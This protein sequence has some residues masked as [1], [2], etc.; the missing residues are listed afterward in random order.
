MKLWKNATFYQMTAEGD[1]V[2]AVLTENGQICAVGEAMGLEKQYVANITE[3]IDLEGKVVFPGFVDAHIHLLWYGQALERL[4]LNQT[5]T[6]KEALALIAERTKQIASDEWLFV[7]G[8]DENKW[9][10]E[11]T[12]ISLADLD[13][14]SQ[15]NPILVRRIDYHSVSINSALQEKIADFSETGFDGGGEIVRDKTGEFIGVLRDNATTMAIDSFPAATPSELSAW[16]EIAITDLWSKGITGAHSEDL[17]YFTGF[18][19]TLAAFRNTIGSNKM[20]FRAH[21]LVH[22]AELAAFSASNESFVSG[23]AF[24]ELGAMKIF[25]DGTVG[26][27]TALMSAG[28]ADNPN[29][30]GLQIHSDQAFEDLVKAARKAGLPVAIHILGDQAFA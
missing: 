24:L 19:S 26:S 1:Q 3:T 14:V 12:L 28:Y 30:K 4:N 10:D 17:H 20:P 22:H 2:S 29:E 6:K 7:E 27:R 15:T 5:T 25:Y 8:Y 23:D 16:L 18:A 13:E 11:Q 21:L 9:S